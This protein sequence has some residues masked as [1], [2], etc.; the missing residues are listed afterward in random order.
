MHAANLQGFF[1][2]EDIECLIAVAAFDAQTCGLLV[3][4]F[5]TRD[6]EGRVAISTPNIHL[7]DIVHWFVRE[8]T[9]GIYLNQYRE[10]R[11]R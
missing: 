7:A 9:I 2:V 11:W 6:P 10:T 1:V 4:S 3:A 8:Q 5:S